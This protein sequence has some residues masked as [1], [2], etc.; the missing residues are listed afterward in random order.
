MKTSRLAP[1]ALA[2]A[3]VSTINQ[4]LSTT[5]AQGGLTPPGA[6]APSMITLSQIEP[7]TPISSAPYTISQPG[8]FFLTT[9]VTVSSANAI[10]IGTNSV[11]LDLNG[12]TISSTAAS[13]TGHGILL[14]SGLSDI[15]IANGHIQGGVTNNGSGVYSGTGFNYGIYYSGTAPVN[16]LVS[17]VSVS[18]CLDHGIYLNNGDSTLVENCTVRT[19]GSDGIFASTVKQSLA[20][21]CGFHAIFA[22]QVSDCQGQSSGSGD[23]IVAATALNCSGSSGSGDGV[24]AYAAQNCYGNSNGSGD[25]VHADYIANGCIGISVSGAGV[26]AFIANVC[27]GASTTGTAISTSHNVNSY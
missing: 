12:F 3:L 7:R 11:T 19:V 2:L 23:G 27:H 26:F 14:K 9:N 5:F 18:G 15:T 8:S 10:I 4:Q 20:I 22:G 21:D 17:R 1:S 24:S 25:G 13:A 6:P 16:V